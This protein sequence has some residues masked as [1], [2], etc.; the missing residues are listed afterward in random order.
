MAHIVRTPTNPHWIFPPRLAHVVPDTPPQTI[1]QVE[2]SKNPNEAGLLIQTFIVALNECRTMTAGRW[3]ANGMTVD[4]VG[5]RCQVVLRY[6]AGAVNI[7]TNFFYLE[8]AA[9]DF[10]HI[11]DLMPSFDEAVFLA[12]HTIVYEITLQ[13]RRTVNPAPRLTR[14][15]AAQPRRSTRIGALSALRNN[16]INGV[17]LLGNGN[18]VG[19]SYHI[20]KSKM[21]HRSVENFYSKTDAL[22]NV[23]HTAL[24][25]CFP[26][27]FIK[28]QL[29]TLLPT[30]IQET[31]GKST[32]D[33]FVRTPENH[34]WLA[35][36]DNFD[37]TKFPGVRR[38]YPTINRH[39]QFIA[40]TDDATLIS[41]LFNPYKE[42]EKVYPDNYE[43][44]FKDLSMEDQ[45]LWVVMAD[46]VLAQVEEWKDMYLDYTDRDE[47]CQAYADFFFVHIHIYTL[48]G[49]GHRKITYLPRSHADLGRH[50]HLVEEDQH[51]YPITHVRHFFS[52]TTKPHTMSLHNYC[53]ICGYVTGDNKTRAMM[54]PHFD[55]CIK[56][57]PGCK[58]H[59]SF[60]VSEEDRMN[61]YKPF[62]WLNE[63]HCL[64]CDRRTK[65]RLIQCKEHRVEKSRKLQCTLCAKE[66]T[67]EESTDHL[68]YI[69]PPKIKDPIDNAKL[70]VYDI[71]AQQNQVGELIQGNRLT[72]MNAF[73]HECNLVCLEAVYDDSPERKI[74][75][76]SS[77]AFCQFL[78][79]DDLMAN[80]YIV[81]HNGGGYDHQY[82]LQ[83]C[84]EHGLVHETTPHPA[85]KHKFLMLTLE[86]EDG[87]KVT[88]IDSMAFITGSLRRIGMDFG[89]PI[90]K[91][92]FPHNFSRRENQDY[93]GSIPPIDSPEDYF[94]LKTK[95][96]SE[97]IEELKAWHA[98]ES[99]V[100]CTCGKDYLLRVEGNDDC[101]M[102]GKRGW[103]FQEQL[104][105]YC[106]LD[107]AV[108]KG[109]IK[110]YREVIMTPAPEDEAESG[111]NYPGLDPFSLLTMS[112]VGI[113]AF[114]NGHIEPVPLFNSSYSQ[115]EGYNPKSNMWLKYLSCRR[116]QQIMYKGTSLR[117][118]YCPYTESYF[119]GYCAETRTV[120]IFY[121]CY[122]EGCTECFIPNPAH[123]EKQKKRMADIYQLTKNKYK[124]EE[125]WEHEFDH[126]TAY[127]GNEIPTEA[128]LVMNDRDFFYGGRTEVFSPYVESTDTHS[129]N[130]YDV[131]SLYPTICAGGTYERY[132][133][134]PIGPPEI[135]HMP[136]GSF[137]DERLDPAHIDAYWGFVYCKVVP[138]KLDVLGLL[139][140][141]D[142]ATGRL[143]FT[144]E[145][146]VGAWHT[147]ELYLAMRHGY[148]VEELYQVYH[149]SRENRSHTFMKG[150]VSYFLRMK[151]EADGWKKA[152][153]ENEDPCE[154]V[155]VNLIKNLYKQN[156]RIGKMRIDK[157][158]K[159]AVKRQ[160]AKLFLNSLWG[161]FAQKQ[162]DDHFTTINGYK[163]FVEFVDC[164]AVDKDKMWF[165]HVK[166]N[167][168]KV[169][170]Q[171]K[172]G[173]SRPNPRYNIFLAASVT[174][175]ARCYLH[176]KM[177][178]VGPANV[179]YCDTDSLQF[180]N[181]LDPAKRIV[182][183]I[184]LG[185]WSDEYPVEYISRI[186]A[187]APKSYNIT[188]TGDD[189]DHCSLKTKGISLTLQNQQKVQTEMLDAML[190]ATFFYRGPQMPELKLDHMNISSNSHY[191]ALPFA[192]L[193]TFYTQK[194]MRPVLTKRQIIPFEKINGE[195]MKLPDQ[196]NRL[197]TVP[198][199]FG[200]EV[201]ELS[202]KIAEHCTEDPYGGVVDLSV[203]HNI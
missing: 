103:N 31:R 179:T 109:V 129:I 78:Y 135:F 99:L 192:T 25:F 1:I 142:K 191:T 200:V 21:I 113:T 111:W 40:I 55:E 91:G 20:L 54:Q 149:W 180:L 34:W 10:Q 16:P 42:V 7:A 186:H 76:L 43:E 48:C 23:P 198:I 44:H 107:V 36:I 49:S 17:R 3:A 94:C 106:W 136:S 87:A 132:F 121:D 56:N 75:F 53:D 118:W 147:E 58:L 64:D 50:V 28:C 74:E 67:E 130:Y 189:G 154:N 173:R 88:L 52:K 24:N 97:E 79:E 11:V 2:I 46:D 12:Q 194:I 193:M 47:I 30:R 8:N 168:F 165:R 33:Q 5:A 70:W 126:L 169:R 85:S 153:A 51:M 45:A 105:L 71:E 159:N 101:V 133:D 143:Q 138:N 22:L 82:V 188:F 32:M 128:C 146:Q 195:Y 114:M 66:V 201:E 175:H 112:Q 122:H 69:N 125:I 72:P 57:N 139:P 102:C 29:R 166:D 100:F 171:K 9:A 141:R 108:L 134:L 185:K 73:R 158:E 84:E 27:A 150:Y 90:A 183:G 98:R 131:V 77:E 15:I 119:P 4:W 13:F 6:N 96:S 65:K 137:P 123:A 41:Y 26:M 68:C 60:Q 196:V 104:K 140:G 182:P 18:R 203:G 37:P 81:A 148:H 197:Y 92:D 83:Y 19:A 93:I 38:E 80:S 161:K 39:N 117:E 160:I 184:G 127:A 202:R 110:K 164:P 120:F 145:D 176:R 89:L 124:I 170:Y 59:Y 163:Q 167:L 181:S 35:Y 63:M 155:K 144:L 178:E 151:Q 115:R 156:G 62:Q 172:M 190:E 61:A 116:N 174:A 14:S 157:V 162:Q 152:G 187:L 86:R 95:R 177:I 199:G